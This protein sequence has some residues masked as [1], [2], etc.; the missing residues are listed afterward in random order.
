MSMIKAARSH[1]VQASQ[2]RSLWKSIGEAQL[3][4]WWSFYAYLSPSP[5]LCPSAF[6]HLLF[7][8]S[9]HPSVFPSILTWTLLFLPFPKKINIETVD[10]LNL[11]LG[12]EL[13]LSSTVR[14]HWVHTSILDVKQ[15]QVE[16]FNYFQDAVV[17]RTCLD[18][19]GSV[20]VEVGTL[21]TYS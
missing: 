12:S 7:F 13:V 1:W 6:C 16:L 14:P 15:N 2:D 8:P 17:P 3:K 18:W 10:I 20:G 19:V 9:F 11:R 5:F 21:G 4:W